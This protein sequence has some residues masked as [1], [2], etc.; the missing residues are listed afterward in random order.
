MSGHL[1]RCAFL[2]VSPRTPPYQVRCRLWSWRASRTDRFYTSAAWLRV[3]RTAISTR[4]RPLKSSGQVASR[5][6]SDLRGI[7][8]LGKLRFSRRA[9]PWSIRKPVELHTSVSPLCLIPVIRPRGELRLLC[10]AFSF[11]RLVVGLRAPSAME[12]AK[13]ATN[14]DR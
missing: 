13:D 9:V 2:Q 3:G 14:G 8:P 1:G 12:R 7:S 6:R 4:A 10:R 11:V 5:T